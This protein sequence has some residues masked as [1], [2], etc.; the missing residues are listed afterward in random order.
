MPMW[1]RPGVFPKL[2]VGVVAL[3]ALLQTTPLVPM[4]ATRLADRW[5]GAAGEV[6]VVLSADMLGDGT[7]G[8][9]SYWRAVYGARVYRIHPFRRVIVCGGP[10]GS[11]RPAAEAMGEFMQ[12]L[13][14]PR[15]A[16]VLEGKSR[17]T[18]E[19]ALFAK[20]LLPA[21]TRQVVL[22][23]S[24][25]HLWRARRTFAKVGL[26][27]AAIPYPDI[28]KRWNNWTYRLPCSMEVGAELVK[29]GYYWMKGWI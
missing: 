18:R 6:L 14:V 23:T 2:A 22:V 16:L 17:S 26:E 1:G 11:T 21:G 24:D 8:V 28:G 15:E 29:I 10:G 5:D 20:E 25:F 9:G 19:N 27:V 12:A 13:G 7:L 4:V 3:L